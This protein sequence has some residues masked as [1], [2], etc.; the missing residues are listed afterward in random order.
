MKG[1][2]IVDH[3]SQKHE[4]NEMLRAMA[5]LI[6]SMAGSDVVVRFAHMELAQPDIAAGFAKC[7]EAGANDVTV[8]PYMLSPGRHSTSDIP[9]MVAQVAHQFPK[10]SFSVTPAFGLHEK[11]AEV[12]LEKAGIGVNAD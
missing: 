3:G 8:F 12:V 6:Q 1:I 10:V 2:L 7:V 4:A 9:R 5:D 11:L